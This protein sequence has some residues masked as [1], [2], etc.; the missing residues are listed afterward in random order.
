[1]WWVP[2]MECCKKLLTLLFSAFYC[3]YNRCSFLGTNFNFEILLWT[4]DLHPLYIIFLSPLRSPPT[5]FPPQTTPGLFLWFRK[6]LTCHRK[7]MG[8]WAWQ[9][10]SQPHLLQPQFFGGGGVLF[11]L[12]PWILSVTLCMIQILQF[13]AGFF[14]F[15]IRLIIF[16]LYQYPVQIIL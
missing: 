5:H 12:I 7:Q 14:L 9:I 11:F 3:I 13:Y 6:W 1:M 10:A 16:N 2:Y 4:S 8:V 15:H